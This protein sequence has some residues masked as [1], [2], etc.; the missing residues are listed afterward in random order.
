MG[1]N[2]KEELLK[3]LSEEQIAKF[4]NWST[5]EEVLALA[6]E[7]GINFVGNI[8]GSKALS[9]MCDVLVAEGFAGNQV[10]KNSEGMAVNLIT[11]IMKFGKMT[12]NEEVT[13]Q[14]AGYI[15][16]TYDFE[17]LGAGIMLGARKLVMKCRGSSGPMAIKNTAKILINIMNNKTFYE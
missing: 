11:E 9:G 3:G 14:I 4:K 17:S 16:K 6:K 5:T 12:G 2:I 15:M 13:K 8:E 1:N 7:E 10:L